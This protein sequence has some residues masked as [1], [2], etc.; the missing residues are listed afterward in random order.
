MC[1]LKTS[2]ILGERHNLDIIMF[3]YMFGS[4]SRG[5]IYRAISMSSGMARKL[6]TLST[7][8][9]VE[10]YEY[11]GSRRKMVK[12]TSLGKEFASALG[13]LELRSGGDLEKY[14]AEAALDINSGPDKLLSPEEGPAIVRR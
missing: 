14:R 4:R 11:E 6:E 3:L 13:N 5:E 9:I 8:G 2:E 12:L 1:K 10:L 7:H